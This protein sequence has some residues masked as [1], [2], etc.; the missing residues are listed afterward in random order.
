[1]E[2][3]TRYYEFVNA[4]PEGTVNKLGW[5]VGG[6]MPFKSSSAAISY[7]MKQY[8]LA[9]PRDGF[10]VHDIAKCRELATALYPEVGRLIDFVEDFSES[11][12]ERTRA[13]A[14]QR[15]DIK[16]SDIMDIINRD[17]LQ[18]KIRECI[19]GSDA[20]SDVWQFLWGRKYELLECMRLKEE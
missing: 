19:G 5:V 1:M 13:L 2:H 9:G 10:I 8:P 17:I 12:R 16:E 7:C 18:E 3:N 6:V 15:D 14:K 4:L 11:N 20:L